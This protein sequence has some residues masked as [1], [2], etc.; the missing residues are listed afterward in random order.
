MLSV[1][2]NLSCLV[3][4]WL[5]YALFILM[6]SINKEKSLIAHHTGSV[7]SGWVVLTSPGP[8][9]CHVSRVCHE[10]RDMCVTLAHVTSQVSQ[11][12]RDGHWCDDDDVDIWEDHRALTTAP[13]AAV[14][15]P[16]LSQQHLTTA[17][18]QQ[19]SV[20]PISSVDDAT[21]T[22][23]MSRGGLSLV[24]GHHPWLLIGWEWPDPDVRTQDMALGGRG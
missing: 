15:G 6:S 16:R 21:T 20:C 5:V 8:H 14:A 3:S 11:V 23:G 19:R 24:T 4:K 1:C 13:T 17:A 10:A 22:P 7:R 18:Q 9:D 12:T 2:F